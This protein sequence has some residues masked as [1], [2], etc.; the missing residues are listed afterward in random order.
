MAGRPLW[1]RAFDG[2]ERPVA[3]RLEQA[4]QTERFADLAGLALRTRAELDRLVERTSRRALHRV[5]MPAASDVVRLREQ[6][7]S[8]ER[9]VRRLDDAVRR[10][11]PPVPAERGTDG[12]DERAGR[13]GGARAPRRRPQPAAGAQR[14]QVRD[15]DRPPEGR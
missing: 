4:V 8:L 5:N 13:P 15:R 6:V 14:R 11:A 1:R 3:G 7:A 12:T 2:V 10:P 9:S